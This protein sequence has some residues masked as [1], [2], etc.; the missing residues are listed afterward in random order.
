VFNSF[1]RVAAVQEQSKPLSEVPIEG[2][3][4]TLTVSLQV[5]FDLD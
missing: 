1:A 2:G 5:R 3:A 4:T